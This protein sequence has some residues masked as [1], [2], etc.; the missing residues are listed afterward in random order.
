M[1]GGDVTALAIFQATLPVPGRVIPN[2][3]AIERAILTGERVFGEIGCTSCHLPSLPIDRGRS[4]FDEPGPFS[5][6]GNATPNSARV[7]TVDL[8]DP[9]L[10]QPRL[11]AA[12]KLGAIEVPAYTDLKLHDITDASDP[13]AAEPLDINQPRLS[14][15]YLKGNRAFLTRR[16]WAA[17]SSPTHFHNGLLTTL[18]GAI[19]A[20]AG[21]A[22]ESRRNFERLDPYRQGSV[23]EFLKSMQA[24][25]PG[26]PSRI[27]DE[28]F[29]PREW[30]PSS[31]R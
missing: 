11:A 2:D 15:A 1:T 7:M 19:L 21:E 22:L 16:L 9:Q 24:L 18:R 30:P 26:T 27:V 13:T 4:L 14:K 17:G 3:P 10:P 23:V 29:R 28:H 5:G 8:T 31:R 6:I 12:H 20:H 25:P